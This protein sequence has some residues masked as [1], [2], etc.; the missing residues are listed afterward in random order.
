MQEAPGP[1]LYLPYRQAATGSM[2]LLIATRGDPAGLVPAVRE[3]MQAV[4]AGVA[5]FSVETMQGLL[6]FALM[7]QWIG[8]WAG[9]ALGGF[10]VLLAVGGLFAL[11]AY[12]VSRRTHEIGIRMALGARRRTTLWMVV[13][14]GLYLGLAGVGVGLPLAVV[15]G[16][17]LGSLFL[18]IAPADP[19]AL[20]G[21]SLTVI[22]VALLASL[23]PAHRATRVDPMAA[24]RSE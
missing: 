6:R 8:A 2:T 16:Y 17:V 1:Y 14:Q 4:D 15:L 13:R 10:T 11:V 7:P 23:A 20:G 12:A 5:P 21:A 18:G 22:A 24:L 3:T 19:M 9:A